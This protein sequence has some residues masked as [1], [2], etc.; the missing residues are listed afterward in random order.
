[1]D[2]GNNQRKRGLFGNKSSNKGSSIGAS[3]GKFIDM[4]LQKVF[5]G[6]II[7]LVV[8]ALL[9][10]LLGGINQRKFV[11]AVF[12]GARSIGEKITKQV[13]PDKVDVNKDG[14]YIRPNGGGTNE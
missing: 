10:V 2:M 11:E 9:W 6:I 1:M 7:L 13:T 8:F 14:V 12:T 5:S 3:T 4:S